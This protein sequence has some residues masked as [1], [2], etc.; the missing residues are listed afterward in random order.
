MLEY[1]SFL[2][3]LFPDTD[4]IITQMEYGA[5]A[6]EADTINWMCIRDSVKAN[7]PTKYNIFVFGLFWST[8]KRQ[9]PTGICRFQINQPLWVD[10]IVLTMKS[11]P[12]PDVGG[13]TFICKADFISVS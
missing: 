6:D 10:E 12:T 4:P 5:L 2:C 3:L 8:R 9:I 1:D 7:P 13:F 11:G